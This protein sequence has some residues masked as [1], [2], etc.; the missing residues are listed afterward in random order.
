M[1]EFIS[2]LVSA[3]L[4]FL[5]GFIASTLLGGSNMEVNIDLLS[6]FL[7]FVTGIFLIGLV[8]LAYTYGQKSVK[9]NEVKR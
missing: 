1:K 7:G 6:Y 4:S 5:F 2:M 3:C 9:R 8:Y